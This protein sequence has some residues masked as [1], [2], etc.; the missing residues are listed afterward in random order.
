MIINAWYITNWKY[1]NL[2]RKNEILK[3][4]ARENAHRISHEYK[5]GDSVF[6]SDTDVKRKLARKQG[7]FK[8]TKVNNN[9]TVVIQRTAMVKETINIRRLHPV[10]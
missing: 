3:N 8:I 5:P 2:K 6:V 9:G 4:N 7:P 1:V 10:F